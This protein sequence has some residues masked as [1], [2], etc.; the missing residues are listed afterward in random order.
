MSRVFHVSG[1]AT[2]MV[3][4][5]TITNG[6]VSFNN[7]GGIYND[8]SILTVSNCILSGNSVTNDGGA[9]YNDGFF[10]S[11]TLEVL[12]SSLI[13]NSAG[14]NGGGIVNEG[15]LGSATLDVVDSTLSGNSAN[16]TGSGI[17][18]IGVQG[19]ATLIINN[20]TLSGNSAFIGAIYSYGYMGSATLE[21]SHSTFNGNSPWGIVNIFATSRVGSTIFNAS[22]IGNNSGTVSS[23]GYN[24]SSDDGSGFLTATGDQVN[25]DPMLGPLEDNGGPTFTHAL[26]NGSPAIDA[27]DPSFVPPPDY[28]QRGAGYDRVAHGRIDIGAF[29]LQIVTPNY[30]GQ[31]QPPINPDGTS[32]FSAS[33]GVVPVKFNLT[34]GGVATCDLPAATIAVTR[35]AGGVTGEVNESVYSNNA[36][37][38]SNFRIDNCQYVYNLNARAVGAGTYRMDILI[39]AQ[40]VG[41]ATFQLR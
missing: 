25:T 1:G 22:P 14:L 19:S 10:G 34:V 13:G 11:A 38:G 24:I 39:N 32:V 7:G 35:T 8:H 15:F 9:I 28:D 20:S 36:D 3:V 23:D 16:N 33:R 12:N 21:V 27:G 2:A 40:V 5:L 37:T 6:S 29:E 41:S 17:S 30:A 26:L 18:N 4:G 31:V